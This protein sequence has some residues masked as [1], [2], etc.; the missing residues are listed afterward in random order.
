MAT[1][2]ILFTFTVRGT[3]R[4][5]SQHNAI[6][7][8]SRLFVQDPEVFLRYKLNAFNQRFTSLLIFSSPHFKR[9]MLFTH[10]KCSKSALL[11]SLHKQPLCWLHKSAVFCF[12]ASRL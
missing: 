11:T 12:K 1:V 10:F 8:E 4:M 3:A 7:L 9:S 2:R 5:F 6:S